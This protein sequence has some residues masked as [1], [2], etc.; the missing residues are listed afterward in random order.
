MLPLHRNPLLY[1]GWRISTRPGLFWGSLMVIALL[2]FLPFA[3]NY[4]NQ[5][6]DRY[7]YETINWTELMRVVCITALV[8]QHILVFILAFGGCADS[9]VSERISKT[10]EFFETLPISPADKVI[11]KLLGT[12]LLCLS[13]AA[14]LAPAVLLFGL[15]GDLSLSVLLWLEAIVFVG[16]LAW[17]LLGLIISRGIGNWRGGWVFV[18]F[19]IILWI[20]PIGLVTDDD[21][22]EVPILTISP[23]AITP[24]S[25]APELAEPRDLDSLATVF[26][27][28]QYHF[29]DW[30]VPWKLC[31]L[32]L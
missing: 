13:I 4:A 6:V 1:K 5:V 18:I 27:E 25:L 16:G 24:A 2:L 28:G 10:H 29:F 3:I 11:G 21:F 26:R 32:V 17:S 20:V 22:R 23:P 15:A 9:I 19:T 8:L 12:N 31:P 30:T 7:N 14:A